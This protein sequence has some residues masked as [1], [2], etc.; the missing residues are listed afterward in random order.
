[1]FA[2]GR[3]VAIAAAIT[4]FRLHATFFSLHATIFLV[5]VSVR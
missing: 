2:G 3:A 5:R 4:L 1:M